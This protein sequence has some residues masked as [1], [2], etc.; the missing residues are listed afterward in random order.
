MH[1]PFDPL[2]FLQVEYSLE[3]SLD[4]SGNIVAD[5]MRSLYPHQKNK[6]KAVLSTYGKL[7]RL[8][9]DAPSRSMRPSVRKLLA[10]GK[11]EIRGGQYVAA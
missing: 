1:T 11:I 2:R 7:L 3:L 10:Q 8:Q 5:G 4:S 6:A 9:L